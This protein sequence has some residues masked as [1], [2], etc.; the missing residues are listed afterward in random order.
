VNDNEVNNSK[1]I[2][3]HP[4]VV[5]GRRVHDLETSTKPYKN[6]GGVLGWRLK[7]LNRR[8]SAWHMTVKTPGI[9]PSAFKIPG[10][11]ND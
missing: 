3:I 9:N 5:N 4:G 1:T 8:Q 2:S 10:S 6:K 7:N 11:M